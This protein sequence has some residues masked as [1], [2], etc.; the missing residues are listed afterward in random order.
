MKKFNYYMMEDVEA[1]VKHLLKHSQITFKFISPKGKRILK[2][3][4]GV[5]VPGLWF[6]PELNKW[7][8]AND[9]KPFIQ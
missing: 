2:Q 6:V 5:Y 3:M 9:I 8:D 1:S 4:R 7:F